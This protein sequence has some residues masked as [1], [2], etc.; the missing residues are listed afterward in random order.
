MQTVLACIRKSRC[1][2][3]GFHVVSGDLSTATP[4]WRRF[5]TTMASPTKYRF[6]VFNN[7]FQVNDKCDILVCNLLF[8]INC[9]MCVGPKDAF[10]FA[11][12]IT[13]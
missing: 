11:L 1:L 4:W 8:F 6:C 5:S 10:S 2:E 13:N 7:I 9:Y 3:I 12:I